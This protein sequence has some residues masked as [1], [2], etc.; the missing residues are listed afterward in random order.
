M[1]PRVSIPLRR[2]EAAHS[3]I[4]L[5]HRCRSRILVL[6]IGTFPL[7]QV[8][9]RR[10]IRRLFPGEGFGI[11]PPPSPEEEEEYQR[12]DAEESQH[13]DDD[14]R[15]GAAAEGGGCGRGRGDR[16]RGE[17]VGGDAHGPGACRIHLARDARRRRRVGDLIDPTDSACAPAILVTSGTSA[18]VCECMPSQT[19][20]LTSR[21]S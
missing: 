10:P 8:E 3:S 13:A 11:P 20:P 14:P 12:D 6:G 2:R 1:F 16:R 18:R 9:S 19:A 15:D 5:E 17:G 7:G 21:Q 4:R